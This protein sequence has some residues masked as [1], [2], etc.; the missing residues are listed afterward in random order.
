VWYCVAPSQRAKFERMAQ[1]L[2]PEL[3][4]GCRS[5]MR[6]KDVLL[7]PQMLKTYGVEYTMVGSLGG[8][9]AGGRESWRALLREAIGRPAAP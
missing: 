2:Y 4:R 8:W 1:S 7:S 3:H 6:H 5:F 9:G